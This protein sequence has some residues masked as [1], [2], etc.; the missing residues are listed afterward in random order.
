MLFATSL[1]SE[2][3]T[4]WGTV[5]GLVFVAILQQWNA[6]KAKKDR[7]EVKL[8]A[9]SLK[10]ALEL[11]DAIKSVKLNQIHALVNGGML[12]Q[13]ALVARLSRRV[14]SLSNDPADVA[15]AE[16]AEQV[17]EDQQKA[18]EAAAV[19]AQTRFKGDTEAAFVAGVQSERQ[20]F[21]ELENKLKSLPCQ[22]DPP[23]ESPCKDKDKGA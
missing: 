18:Q 13:L 5:A 4:T 19:A 3:G 2:L 23:T 9:A 10:D 7:L 14:A 20:R 6:R 1:A 16:Q 8:T 22:A 15:V 11:S 17:L 12:K 21:A